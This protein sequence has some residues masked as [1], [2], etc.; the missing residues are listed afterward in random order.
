MLD[1]PFED[2]GKTG[3]VEID[4]KSF[5][6]RGEDVWVNVWDFGGQE[7]YHTTHKFFF[8]ERCLY[9]L[10][11]DVRAGMEKYIVKYWLRQIKE[12]AKSNAPLII[13]ANKAECADKNEIDDNYKHNFE[14]LLGEFKEI[15]PNIKAVHYTSTNVPLKRMK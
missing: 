14:S 8:R 13:V 3:G 12:L 1:L 6:V 15:Y 4:G 5:K 9:I 7:V 10:V 11:V 2:R